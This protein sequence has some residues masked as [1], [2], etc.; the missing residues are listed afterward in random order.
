MCSRFSWTT[1]HE[2]V[3]QR[4]IFNYECSALA[5]GLFVTSFFFNVNETISVHLCAD[6]RLDYLMSVLFILLSCFPH[7]WVAGPQLAGL[8]L[9]SSLFSLPANPT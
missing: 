9:A 7:F 8:W 6:L 4:L 1:S 5:L 2:Y 3:R